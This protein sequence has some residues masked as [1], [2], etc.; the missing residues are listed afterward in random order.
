MALGMRIAM[1]GLGKGLKKLRKMQKG[2]KRM[3]KL[4]AKMKNK[5]KKAM[6]AVGV[7]PSAQNKVNKAICAVTGHPV[8]LATGKVFTE[9]TDLEL[10]GP[11]PFKFERVWYSCSEY[12]GPF[13]NNWHH[14]YD[15]ALFPGNDAGAVRLADGR[16]ITFPLLEPGQSHFDR[17]ERC[18]I[19]RDKT[20]YFLQTRDLLRYI[21]SAE[22]IDGIHRL[23]AI[24]DTTGNAIRFSYDAR[25][26]LSWIDD[27]GGRSIQVIT[28]ESGHIIALDVPHPNDE[29]RLRVASYSYDD[30]GNLIAVLDAL[31][32]SQQYLYE[33]RLLIKETYR[34]GFSF[35]FEYSDQHPTARCTRT[36]GDDGIYDHKIDYDQVGGVTK[37]TDSLGSTRQYFLDGDSG[38]V[39]GVVDPLGNETSAVYDDNNNRI[40]ET[41]PLGNTTEYEYDVRGNCTKISAADGAEMSI[42]Y[43]HFDHPVKC[44]D[45]AGGVWEYEYDNFGRVVKRKNPLGEISE[46]LFSGGMPTGVVDGAGRRTNVQYDAAGNLIS[47]ITPNGAEQRFKY[48]SLGRMVA[49]QNSEGGVERCHYDLLGRPIRYELLD[50]TVSTIG[51]DADDNV[52]H[53][54]EGPLEVKFEYS[55]TGELVRREQDGQATTLCYDTELQLREVIDEAGST[56]RFLMDAC[57]ET[58]AEITYSGARYEY[59]RDAAGR[60]ATLIKPSGLKDSFTYD[61]ADRVIKI[62]HSDGSFEQFAYDSAGELVNASNA[63]SEIEFK[64][65]LLGRV[66]EES[67]THGSVSSTFDNSGF[68]NLLQTSQNHEQVLKRNDV[69]DVLDFQCRQADHDWSMQSE[70]NRLG[71]EIKRRTTGSETLWKIDAAGR[72]IQHDVKCIEPFSRRYTWT[73]PGLIRM[74]DDSRFGETNYE[75]DSSGNLI[76]ALRSDGRTEGKYLDS[77]GNAYRSENLSDRRFGLD[78]Q[79]LEDSGETYEYNQDGFLVSKHDKYGER[80]DYSWNGSGF[81]KSVRAPD[82]QLTKY[83]YDALG[84]RMVKQTTDIKIEWIWDGNVPIHEIVKSEEN[85]FVYSWV[86]KPESFYPLARM[87]DSATAIIQCD[88]IGSPVA[89]ISPDGES[90]WNG[91]ID[92]YGNLRHDFGNSD[93]CPFRFQGQYKDRETGLHYNRFRMYDPLTGIFAAPDPIGLIAGLA[94]YGYVP[95]P[96]IFIDPFGLDWNYQ[97]RDPATGEVYYSGRA[98]DKQTP[99]D[100]QRRHAATRG[101][102][103]PRFRPGTDAF[104]QI[105]PPGTS[106]NVARGIEELGVMERGG[107]SALLGRNSPKARGNKIRG[108]S[109]KS[110]N[111]AKYLKAARG[112]LTRRGASKISDLAGKVC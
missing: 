74:I 101:S 38:L 103:G 24:R 42:E 85:E 70:F 15:L 45:T 64:R 79:L 72:T 111:R 29:G 86:M 92:I 97:L 88:H 57:G 41:D 62:S 58:T 2:S 7:P 67:G 9:C 37:V 8:D 53:L 99:A 39:N 44:I 109:L 40:S 49:S 82:G 13:G 22:S 80:W 87:S 94:L 11:I 23:S 105:T 110:K 5:A 51:Y 28:D 75:H 59:E 100:V 31:G 95:D 69:G 98:S 35:F 91:E 4:S 63:D 73:S 25:G 90:L 16:A 52:V 17:A 21:F 83:Q 19:G 1:K 61:S 30:K 54:R 104:E 14:S 27:S 43:N 3:A 89:V 47:I 46:F 32:Q 112:H 106:R 48:D 78:G 50:G 33:Q 10:S 18:T 76:S 108:V 71:H 55:G 65:D 68:R 84:R 60:V 66:V 107:D 20:G 26:T 34:N 56:Y 77:A 6:D 36:W 96:L 81:L 93:L 12:S 102:D